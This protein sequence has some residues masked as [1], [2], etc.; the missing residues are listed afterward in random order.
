MLKDAVDEIGE[1]TPEKQTRLEKMIN[2]DSE[3][4]YLAQSRWIG[5]MEK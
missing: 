4:N 3:G 2:G 1:D 5:I